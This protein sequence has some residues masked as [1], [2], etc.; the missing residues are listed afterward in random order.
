MTLPYEVWEARVSAH[1]ERVIGL[2][3]E[4]LPDLLD[5]AGEWEAGETPRGAAALVIETC[6]SEILF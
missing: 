6:G 5:L 2:A 4:D 1:L 3:L